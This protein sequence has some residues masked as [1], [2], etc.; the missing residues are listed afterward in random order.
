MSHEL[1]YV[2]PYNQAISFLGLYP[3]EILGYGKGHGQEFYC[4]IVCISK[5]LEWES[6]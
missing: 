5:N 4:N 1:K 3:G 6:G 2:Y